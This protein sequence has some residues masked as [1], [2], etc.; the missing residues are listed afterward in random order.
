MKHRVVWTFVALLAGCAGPAPKPAAPEPPSLAGLDP[1]TPLGCRYEKHMTHGQQ[2]RRSNLYFWREAQ[3]TE[4]RD[5]ASKQGEIWQRDGK[6]KLFY[7]R[8]FYPERVALEYTPG[9]LATVGSTATWEQVAALVDPQALGKTLQVQGRTGFAGVEAERYT[10][11]ENGVATEIDWLPGLKLP[12]RVQRKSP[13]GVFELTLAECADI[14]KAKQQPITRQELD[15]LRHIDFTDLG[16]MESDPAV[17]R[18]EAQLGGHHHEG[19]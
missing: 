11:T 5:E 15:G 7:T 13:E 12:A 6:D 16:D 14:S 1:S 3:R 8:L 17:Q 18:I 4:T 19:H 10:G 2:E 9:D